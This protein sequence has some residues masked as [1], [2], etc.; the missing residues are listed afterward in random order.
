MKFEKILLLFVFL[1]L[2]SVLNAQDTKYHMLIGTYTSPGKSEGIYVYEFDTQTASIAYKNKTVISS[3]SYLAVTK[4]RKFVYAVSEA[5][6]SKIN[7]FAYNSKNGVLTFLNSQPSGSSGPTYISVDANGKYVFAA[8]YG[9]GSLTAFPVEKDGFLGSDIQ[10]IKHEGRS[11]VKTK[12]HVHSAVLS[13]DNK[14]VIAAD[15]GTDKLNIYSFNPKNRPLPLKPAAQAF[16]TLEPGSGPRH[17][18]FH[19][20]KKFIY[21]VTELSSTVNAFSYKD[22]HLAAIQTISMLPA[23]YTGK[24]DGADIHVSADGKFL[25]A[26]TRNAVNEIVIYSINQKSGKLTLTGRQS[27]TGKSSR[28]FEIDPSGNWMVVTNQGTNTIVVF[29]RDQK[30]GLLSP[31]GQKIEIDRPSFV[32]FVKID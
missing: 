8:N 14:Y 2:T 13:P 7:A 25:Y 1:T 32:K 17:S 4:D 19:P 5:S 18:A 9:G 15:L 29:K 27:T 6:A 3:P 16:V 10:D 24:G 20:N 12:P 30:T 23:G 26:S 31:T 21:A 22:G 28:T 11:I